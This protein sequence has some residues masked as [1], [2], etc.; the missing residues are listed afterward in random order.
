MPRGYLSSLS[1]LCFIIILIGNAKNKYLIIKKGR[2]AIPP[3]LFQK[4]LKTK[5]F[6]LKYLVE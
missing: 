3:S 6:E 2:K 4:D 5:V 1:G